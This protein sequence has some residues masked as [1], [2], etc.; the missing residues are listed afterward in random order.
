MKHLTGFLALFLFASLTLYAAD[1]S[2]LTYTTTGGEVTITDCDEAATGELII[3]DTIEG[4][5]VTTIGD[6]A[7]FDCSSLTTVTIPNGVTSIEDNA[8]RGCFNLTGVTIPDSVTNL[9]RVCFAGCTIL[10]SITI[11]E[12]VTSI[13]ASTFQQCRSLTSITIP[14]SVTSIG[15]NAFYDCTSLTSITIPDSVTSIGEYAFY[16]CTN[17]TNITIPDGVTSLEEG[18]FQLCTNLTS[19]TIGNGVTTIGAIVFWDCT[20]LTNIT[21]PNSVTTLGPS[22]FYDCTSLTSITFQGAAPTVWD[23]TFLNVPDEAVAQVTSENLGSY[24]WNGLILGTA[25]QSDTIADLEAQLAEAIAQRDAAVAERDARPTADQLA[26]AE[27]D[28]DAVIADI[29]LAFDRVNTAAGVTDADILPIEEPENAPSEA[30]NEGVIARAFQAFQINTFD[31]QR[32]VDTELAL[33]G[34]DGNLIAQNDDAQESALPPGVFRYAS[35]LDFPDG[36]P[37][38]IYYLAA[39]MYN[40]TF[41]ETDFEAFTD[42]GRREYTLNIPSINSLGFVTQRSISGAFGFLTIDWY[43]IEIGRNFNVVQLEP[44]TEMFSNLIEDRGSAIAE[45]DA[46]IAERDA[47]PT[48]DQL[49]AVEAE[50]DARFTEDQIRALSADYTI[51]LNDAG[52][53]QMKFNLFESADLNTFAPLTLN[54]DSV[55]VVD[56]SIC[57]ELAPEDRAAFFR[58]SVE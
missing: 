6:G 46:A 56:G 37:D 32:R 17:I 33:Y 7:F 1:L 24:R 22:A 18:T 19:I 35:Q 10:T 21:I 50:R 49:A 39:G 20:S 28:R 38:G 23:N 52:N 36:L 5:P 30:Q 51:G 15:N 58:F 8:F 26:A 40:S 43:R 47:R 53:V 42:S 27:A 2:D 44:L 25:D 45:R 9:G 16:R 13:G 12:G 11:P 57:L 14:D 29:Q 34:S 3:P 54:P 55:S 31:V 41:R 4:N 48:V